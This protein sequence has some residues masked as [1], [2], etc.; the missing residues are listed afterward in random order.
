MTDSLLQVIERTAT[1]W[2]DPD[3][4]RRRDATEKFLDSDAPFSEESVVFAVNQLMSQLTAEAIELWIGGRIVTQPRRVTAVL[5]AR[6]PVSGFRELLAALVTGH[7]FRCAMQEGEPVLLAAFVGEMRQTIDLPVEFIS[8]DLVP[9][10]TDL[11]IADVSDDL[12]TDLVQRFEELGDREGR[13]L[14]LPETFSVAVLDGK[15][16]EE[17]L[18]YLAEDV[19]L[20]NGTDFRSVALIWAP[21]GVSP[22]PL[23]DAFAQFR[24]IVPVHPRIPG[25]LKMQVAF[26]KARNIPHA[27][28][29]GMEFLL[30]K[31]A[32]DVQPPGHVRWTDYNDLKEVEDWLVEQGS[33]IETVVARRA[34]LERLRSTVPVQEPGFA[35]R[36]ELEWYPGGVDLIGF[37][38]G[39][40]TDRLTG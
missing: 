17:D 40:S 38:A 27:F 12:R 1:L 8:E 22:D 36:P 20:Y 25:S 6:T 26:L 14:L 31:G 23:L 15:E 2:Q 33:R 13:L 21:D 4:E 37:L 34:M 3:Y 28:G 29:E 7:S 16:R 32:P 10:G 24:G 18:E 11:L 9:E 5:K 39:E 19:L 30:S 35:H